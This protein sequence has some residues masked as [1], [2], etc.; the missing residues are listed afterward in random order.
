MFT[1][2]LLGA[3]L[4]TLFRV[5]V[6]VGGAV[7]LFLIADRAYEDSRRW[8]LFVG[9][10]CVYAAFAYLILPALVHAV[11]VA[12]RS[13][14]IPGRAFSTDGLPADPV[15]IV[16]S[17]TA[18]DLRAAFRAAGWIE[19]Q[20]LTLRTAIR[21]ATCFVLNRPYPDAPF[22]PLIL[23]GRRQD[24]GFQQPIGHSPRKRNHVRFWAAPRD[25]IVRLSD[26]R[27]WTTGT[28]VD[29][30]ERCLWA[31]TA[32]EDLGFGLTRLTFQPTHRID[33]SVDGERSHVMAALAD[34]GRVTGVQ[35]IDPG[36]TI[37]GRFVS[38]GR[39]AYGVLDA[40]TTAGAGP[41]APHR[42]E[43]PPPTAP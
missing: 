22:S 5:V 27:L 10:V 4:R 15:N 23:F 17:G 21:V 12:T 39:I 33:H 34:A 6:L 30:D 25:M 18:N 41:V 8:G 32:S 3:L 7:V 35:F 40:P 26:M 37:E 19:A 1:S 13:G 11:V 38:D 29:P 24:H 42:T 28:E 14:R 16:L 2:H 20:R 43:A 36:K 9:L 31:G